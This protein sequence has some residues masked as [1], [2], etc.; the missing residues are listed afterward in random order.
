MIKFKTGISPVL[1]IKEINPL[2]KNPDINELKVK[3]L[4]LALESKLLIELVKTRAINE[5]RGKNGSQCSLLYPLF[6][7]PKKC[8]V[9]Q[10][11]KNLK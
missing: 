5:S 8:T 3:S 1:I 7:I 4:L 6:A 10:D 2:I 9:S 11:S